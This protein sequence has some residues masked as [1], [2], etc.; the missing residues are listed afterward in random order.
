MRVAGYLL[1]LIMVCQILG[2]AA[3]PKGEDEYRAELGSYK[4]LRG[5]VA[6]VMSYGFEFRGPTG[7]LYEVVCSDSAHVSPELDQ[8]EAFQCELLR[9]G[10]V[11]EILGYREGDIV[12]ALNV[13]LKGGR[14]RSG[15]GNVKSTHSGIVSR[16]WEGG[17]SLVEFSVSSGSTDVFMNDGSISYHGQKTQLRPGDRVL[18]HGNIVELT[19]QPTER[20]R[21]GIK[22][23]EV[24]V[25]APARKPL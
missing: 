15:K 18:V 19:R 12:Y 4:T 23:G 22:A 6:Q 24:E 11:V 9:V 16:T 17:F 14:F 21:Y 20:V 25:M 8:Y 7:T 13:T 10:D 1:V 2:A 5:R 3:K